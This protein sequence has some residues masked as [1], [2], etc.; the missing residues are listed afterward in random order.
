MNFSDQ[1]YISDNNEGWCATVQE[2]G[3]VE[4]KDMLNTIA[5]CQLYS[6]FIYLFIFFI[7]TAANMII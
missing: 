5:C 4:S 7:S 1:F 2:M 3:F 6:F